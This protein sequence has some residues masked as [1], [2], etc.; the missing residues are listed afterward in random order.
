MS[1]PDRVDYTRT[2]GRYYRAM[3]WFY[4]T[5]VVLMAPVLTLL[6][7]GLLNPLWFRDD[8]LRWLQNTIE[9]LTARRNYFMYRLYLGMDPKV[10]KKTTL[11]PSIYAGFLRLKNGRPK[12]LFLL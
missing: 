3:T 1:L 7:I 6:L 5:I 9:R 12:W 10:C 11:N 8:F 4:F 2:G